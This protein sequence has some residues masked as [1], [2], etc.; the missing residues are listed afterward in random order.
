MGDGALSATTSATTFLEEMLWAEGELSVALTNFLVFLS[1]EFSSEGELSGEISSSQPGVAPIYAEGFLTATAF[2]DEGGLSGTA[3]HNVNIPL[4]ALGALD[5]LADIFAAAGMDA[6]GALTGLITGAEIADGLRADA[7]PGAAVAVALAAAGL[8]EGEVTNFLIT[9]STTLTG[10]ATLSAE[11]EGI[12]PILAALAASGDVTA[13]AYQF[14]EAV[15]TLTGS[16][17]LAAAAV[18]QFLRTG[19]LAG[20]G[21]DIA[22]AFAKYASASAEGG[23]GT[24]TASAYPNYPRSVALAGSGT[25]SATAAFPAMSAAYTTYTTAGAFSYDIPYWATH[26]DVVL[27]GGGGGGQGGAGA[28]IIGSGGKGGHWGY[29]TLV[30][31]TDIGWSV[32]AITGSVGAGGLHGNGGVG[33]GPAADGSPTTATATGWAGLSGDGGEEQ[34]ATTEGR[35]GLAPSPDP[36]SFNGES[37]DGG[38][39]QSSGGNTGAAGNAPGGGG[40]GGAGGIFTGYN[41]GDGAVGKA[42][43]KAYQA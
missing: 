17:Q 25:A 30:R 21:A 27:I 42:W 5:V 4:N 12:I 20:V 19:D 14:V 23:V 31:G 22:A 40:Q 10:S 36:L 7:W 37:Y 3:W 41:G 39:A 43:F 34:N 15:A 11:V 18:Q 2:E 28:F 8:L 35:T 29:T 16:G 1:E 32:T 26:V 13:F 33:N 24:V 9:V 38:N 6:E